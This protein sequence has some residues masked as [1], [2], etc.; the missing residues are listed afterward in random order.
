MN[1]EELPRNTVK[2]LWPYIGESD[3]RKV[4]ATVSGT[5]DA[6][7]PKINKASETAKVHFSKSKAM[8]LFNRYIVE[9]ALWPENLEGIR[10]NKAIQIGLNESTYGE[11]QFKFWNAKTSWVIKNVWL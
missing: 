5:L 6:Y 10:A 8:T 2:K 1:V 4:V 9:F 7:F 3:V 11:A